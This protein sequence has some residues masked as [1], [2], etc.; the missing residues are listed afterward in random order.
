MEMGRRGESEDCLASCMQMTWFYG[1]TVCRGV[2]FNA[3]MR[4]VMILN[5]EEGLKCEVHIDGIRLE[6]VS[7]FKYL[8][9]VLD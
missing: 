2:K 7:E 8:D 9:C 4:K 3:G 6:H 1:E 5:G